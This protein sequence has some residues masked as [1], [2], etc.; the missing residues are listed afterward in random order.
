M[1]SAKRSKRSAVTE[2]IHAPAKSDDALL[3][4]Q[5]ARLRAT[6]INLN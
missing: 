4:A 3:A 1:A 5:C 2:P 6:L